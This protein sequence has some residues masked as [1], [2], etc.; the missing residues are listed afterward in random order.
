[1]EILMENDTKKKD[2]AAAFYLNLFQ[3]NFMLSACT[4]GGGFVIITLMKRKF[5]EEQKLLTEEEMLDLTAIAQSAPGALAI[6]ASIVV[7]YRLL[8]IRGALVS[9][10]GTV[11]PPL[12]IISILSF[13]YN[14]IKDNAVVAIALQVM[15]AGVAAVIFDVVISLAA[16]IFKTK[17]L[18]WIILMGI[19]FI[20]SYFLGVSAIL[21]IIVCG[22][23]GILNIKWEDRRKEKL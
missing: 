10:L 19:A 9:T 21:I 2:S 7:G 17:K 1:M 20:A 12:I 3:T 5:V 22:L 18:L 15:R 14:S 6:N 13:C 8:G 16:T 23:L 4:F 11:L